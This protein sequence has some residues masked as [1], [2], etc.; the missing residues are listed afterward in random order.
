MPRSLINTV[1]LY[2]PL[3]VRC[4]AKQYNLK[5]THKGIKKRASSRFRQ[6]HKKLLSS[7]VRAMD[8][9]LSPGQVLEPEPQPEPP[10]EWEQ[11]L[12]Y[13]MICPDCKE[14]PPNIVEDTQAGDVICES[15]GIVL[16]QRGIDMRAEWRTFANDDQGNDDPSRVGDAPNLLL[17]GNQL[18]T[19]IAFA[20]GS[21][22]SKDLHRAQSKATA[23]K[24]NKVL[25]QA[26]KQIGAYC[27]KLGLTQVVADGAKHIYKDAEE[28]KA[29]KGK[30]QEAL[31]G[32]C[33]IIA[34]RRNNVSRTF[35]EIHH[36]TTATKKDI[37]KTFKA[38][39]KYLIHQDRR[40]KAGGPTVIANGKSLIVLVCST[41]VVLMRVRA[42]RCRGHERKAHGHKVY[43]TSRDASSL[44]RQ[45]RVEPDD[46]EPVP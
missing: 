46:A 31:I 14:D 20:D 27:D 33:L 32:A 15:C 28:S 24:G 8:D 18:Q 13:R 41:T 45:V 12:S 25:L 17:G 36:L 30:S 21:A 40:T 11:N 19:S 44:L 29:F 42:P 34:C 5:L 26:F 43:R 39:E 3:F 6:E 38:L 10:K 1:N 23:D 16:S 9:Y 35:A 22:R 4:C 2:S 37:G 7:P